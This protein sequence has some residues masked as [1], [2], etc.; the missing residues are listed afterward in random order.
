[1]FFEQRLKGLKLLEHNEVV[2]RQVLMW[3][4]YLQRSG[5]LFTEPY[6]FLQFGELETFRVD[7]G[8][9][10]R[11]WLGSE[12]EDEVNRVKTDIDQLSLFDQ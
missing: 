6:P 1:M 11:D 3:T 8:V 10:D 7:A 2:L 9:D 12:D 4:S 5:D